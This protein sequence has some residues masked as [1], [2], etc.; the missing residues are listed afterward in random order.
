M[1]RKARIRAEERLLE[2]TLQR[3]QVEKRAEELTE[4]FNLDI[5]LL[6]QEKLANE[7]AF[8]ALSAVDQKTEILPCKSLK[9]DSV[10]VD[11]KPGVLLT[12]MACFDEDAN[13]G[14]ELKIA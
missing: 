12:N 13:P 2:M 5:Q 9:D 14:N 7:E 1:E 4:Q 10:A 8:A 6:R 3:D 11:E